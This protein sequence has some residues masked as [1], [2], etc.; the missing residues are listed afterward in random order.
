LLLCFFPFSFFLF[1]LH[2]FRVLCIAAALAILIAYGLSIS[3]AKD[4]ASQVGWITAGAVVILGTRKLQDDEQFRGG[5][6]WGTA[7]I[8]K[9]NNH[10]D[11]Q[12]M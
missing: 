6:A 1:S 3:L 5:R 2:K 11:V 7:R 9:K 10:G 8:N 12:H 4:N